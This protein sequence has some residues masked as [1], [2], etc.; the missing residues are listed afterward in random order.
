MTAVAY[1][2]YSTTNQQETSIAAQIEGIRSFCDRQG[3]ELSPMFYIDEARTGTNLDRP[4]FQRL[5][6]DARDRKFDAVVVYDVSRGSRN[7]A[8]WFSFRAQMQA[9]GVQV[10]SATNTLGDPDDP[11]AFLME[12]LSVGMGQHMVLQSRQKS[13]A[14]MR[15]RA[16]RGMFCGGIAPLGYRIEDGK[17][18]IDEAEARAVRHIYNRYA[19]GASYAQ[20]IDELDRMGVRSRQ[21]NRI[22]RPGLNEILKNVRYTGRFLWF[23]R[24]ER[25][26]HRHVGKDNPDKIVLDNTIPPIIDQ[27]LFDRVQARMSTNQAHHRTSY[28]TYLLSGKIRCGECGSAMSGITTQAKGH[29]YSKYICLGKRIEKRCALKNVNADELEN[30]VRQGI[31]DR[32]LN[33]EVMEIAAQRLYMELSE[34]AEEDPRTQLEAELE[35]LRVRNHRLVELATELGITPE[36]KAQLR[37]NETRRV[38]LEARLAELGPKG[39]PITYDE[40]IGVLR[41][42]VARLTTDPEGLDALARD[43]V[44]SVT[45][46][47]DRIEIVYGLPEPKIKK[48]RPVHNNTDRT[49]EQLPRSGAGKLYELVIMRTEKEPRAIKTQGSNRSALTLPVP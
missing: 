17:Y 24:E 10:F 35:Q 11:N 3:I 18:V 23:D 1:A 12:L 48:V 49:M 15:V 38:E 9:L 44:Q 36:Y 43:Y 33:P 2:R 6:A 25:H 46:Y 32:V 27:E 37:E 47:H 39:Q 45:V 30:S 42:D 20:I 26:M 4:G 16:S 29:S 40:I 41:R 21:G 7:V 13:I 5:L 31:I 28:R 19:S 34:H 22:E 14:G 8:D